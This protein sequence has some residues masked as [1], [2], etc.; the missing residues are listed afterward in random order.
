[1]IMKPAVTVLLAA[2]VIFCCTSALAGSVDIGFV[3]KA[4]LNRWMAG[5]A[6]T[7]PTGETACTPA[8]FKKT[9]ACPTIVIFNHS[10]HAVTLSFT[11][12]S[13]DFSVGVHGL[14]EVAHG[15]Q[16]CYQN[17]NWWRLQPGGRCYA[18][19]EFW[20]RTGEV[21]HATIHV[22]AASSSGSTSASFKVKGTSDYSP[23]LQA[24]EEVRQRH[25][26]E[27][28]KIPHLASVELDDNDG[29][30]IDV[31]VND[32]G[33]PPDILED[34]IE[35]VRRQVPLKIEG[36]DTEVTQYVWHAYAD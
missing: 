2:I 11:S 33:L 13:E 35:D 34:Y 17:I 16:P 19:V 20:P 36:Y 1:M 12:D 25:A 3:D 26:S 28:M 7:V 24:A 27:L 32:L 14:Y 8:K 30:K 5:G 4:G 6:A 9:S 21:H 23:E 31:T 10:S 18:P 29:I 15:P 22:S